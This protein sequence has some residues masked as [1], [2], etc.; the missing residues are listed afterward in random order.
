MDNENVKVSCVCSRCDKIHE[1]IFKE[2]IQEITEVAIQYGRVF[3]GFHCDDCKEILSEFHEQY[4]MNE[5]L[6]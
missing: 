2:A 3:F 4:I 5:L 6:K 1:V